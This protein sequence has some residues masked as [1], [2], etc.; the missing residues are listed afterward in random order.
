MSP[1]SPPFTCQATSHNVRS[2]WQ[3]GW[4]VAWVLVTAA[5]AISLAVRP[6]VLPGDEVGLRK[7]QVPVNPEIAVSQTFAMTSDGLHGFEFEPEALGGAPSGR[8]TYELMETGSGVVRQGELPVARVLSSSSYTVEFE[9]IED[10][11]DAVYR[12]DLTSSRSEPAIGIAVWATKG[13]RYPDG[14]MQINGRDRWGDL[15]FKVL[16]PGGQSA[17]TRLLAMQSPPP[18]LS[19]RGMILVALAAYLLMSAFVLRAVS[20]LHS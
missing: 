4:A 8:L 5:A 14:V 3:R 18:G 1:V 11:K 13:D 2:L 16:A 7:F 19:S 9:P 17:W 12:F 6:V 20:R 15:A 10:S